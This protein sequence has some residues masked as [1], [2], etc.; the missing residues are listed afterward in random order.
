MTEAK[1]K[2]K[3]K[4]ARIGAEDGERAKAEAS[5]RARAWAEVEAKEKAEIARV[6][7]Q[8]SNKAKAEAEERA[9]TTVRVRD[10]DAKISVE[11]AA[12][13]IRAVAEA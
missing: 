5:E 8:A 9:S 13:K 2:E 10:N 12:P 4:I 11:E 6:A 3:D 7:D 1:A